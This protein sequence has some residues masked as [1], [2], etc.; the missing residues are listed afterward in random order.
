MKLKASP[1]NLTLRHTFTIARSSSDIAENVL[2]AITDGK[3][4]GYGESAPARY[5]GQTQKSSI[6]S[7][8]KMAAVLAQRDPFELETIL[9]DLWHKFRRNPARLPQSISLCMT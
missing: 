2:V 5:Y 1:L 6:L 4:T 7:I 8:N 3:F 9:G